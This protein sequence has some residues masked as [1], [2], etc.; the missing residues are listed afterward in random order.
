MATLFLAGDSTCAYNGPETNP[1]AGWGQY[2]GDYLLAGWTVDN[3]A[4]NGRSTKSFRDQGR[5]A[6]ILEKIQAGDW[7]FIQFGHNDQKSEDPER[8]CDP[9]TAYP[10]NLKTMIA[11]VR[12]KGAFPVVLSSIARRL[13]T[14][15]GKIED[16]LAPYPERARAV[17]AA[18]GVPFIDANRLVKSWL[19]DLGP[20]KSLAFFVHVAPGQYPHF[21]DGKEDNTH[22]RHEGARVVASFIA[23]AGKELSLPMFA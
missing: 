6:A 22:L 1:Q 15:E 8:Y 16:K 10:E 20:Q 17:A 7:V 4:M 19:E 14:A 12:Q 21:P 5:F 11:E 18:E 9:D 13:F 23:A 2:I 3:H